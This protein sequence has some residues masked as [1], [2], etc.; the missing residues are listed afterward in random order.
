MLSV[1][2]RVNLLR[3]VGAH[4]SLHA[5]HHAEDEPELLEA[6]DARWF[7][8]MGGIMLISLY[9]VFKFLPKQYVDV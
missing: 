2:D 8:I 7:P 5:K 3:Y 9:L 4:L 1:H 6:K